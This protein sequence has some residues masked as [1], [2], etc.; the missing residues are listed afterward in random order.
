L[1]LHVQNSPL[2]GPNYEH[3]LTLALNRLDRTNVQAL[4]TGITGGKALPR[5]VLD[6]IAARTDGVPLFI[7]E[8]T[9]TILESGMLR[10]TGDRFELNG[11][12]PSLAIPTT[13][14]ASLIAR[15]DR[16]ASVKDVAQ[17][18]AVIGREFP[19][20]LLAAVAAL[21]E[22]EFATAENLLTKA[23]AVFENSGARLRAAWTKADLF[24]LH[25]AKDNNTLAKRISSLHVPFSKKL[26]L[27]LTLP[28]S[29]S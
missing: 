1:R 18:G 17:I 15:L 26:M 2:P 14:Q 19:H 5:E 13:L 7:E 24:S 9:R 4:V 3:I 21:P 6:Q 22:R 10:E 20:A 23:L 29:R 11:P 12:L 8:L 28:A 27:P 16:L 25:R